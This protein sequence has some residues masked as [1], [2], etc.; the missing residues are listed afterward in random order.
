MIYGEIGIRSEFV[1]PG[2]WKRK[3]Q[4]EA[5]FIEA[6][7]GKRIYRTGDMGRLLWDGSI[8][9]VKRRDEQVKVRGYRVELGEIESVLRRLGGVSGAVVVARESEEGGRELIGYIKEEV[10]GG[11]DTMMIKAKLRERLPE[12][13]V[14][15]TL[16]IVREF[17]LTP[18]GKVDKR[19]LPGPERNVGARSAG[20]LHTAVEEILAGIWGEALRREQI[21]V[22]DDFFD[23]GGHSL[24]ATQV[25][26]R[27][28]RI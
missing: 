19:A 14:P 2:Y 25:I 22:E 8:E 13:M 6:G 21:S 4:T 9:Y 1:A 20:R 28:R 3:E 5:A 27:V 24:L 15:S 7:G 26:S 11:A 18:N 10:S 17:P 12:Y 23:L 16:V